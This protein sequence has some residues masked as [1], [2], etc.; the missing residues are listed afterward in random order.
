[1]RERHEERE[2]LLAAQEKAQSED[3]NEA[4]LDEDEEG[5]QNSGTPN[6]HGDPN[7]TGY[8]FA[9]TNA[10]PDGTVCHKRF[11]TSRALDSHRR[12]FHLGERRF[13]CTR[14]CGK[15]FGYKHTQERHEAAGKCAPVYDPPVETPNSEMDDDYFREEGGAVPQRDSARGESAHTRSV[16]PILLSGTSPVLSK[17]TSSIVKAAAGKL[18]DLPTRKTKTHMDRARGTDAY[19]HPSASS[20]SAS[21]PSLFQLLIGEGYAPSADATAAA[22]GTSSSAVTQSSGAKRAREDETP[23]DNDQAHDS[24]VKRRRKTR[25][26]NLAC[27]WRRIV[28]L[29]RAAKELESSGAS[30]NGEALSDGT[31]DEPEVEAA[32]AGDAP[33]CAFRFSRMY[34]LRRHVLSKHG[35]DLTRFDKQALSAIM[36]EQ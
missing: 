36:A 2:A 18:M 16:P 13:Q 3:D 24:Q 22:V 21:T 11:K 27:P 5:A 23:D 1:M 7:K 12:V 19:Q 17:A 4:D 20:P 25:E 30:G 26:R 6:T 28:E 10:L 15:R 33:D 32:D 34:D 9:C 31:E 29:G 35:V 8:R 14:G